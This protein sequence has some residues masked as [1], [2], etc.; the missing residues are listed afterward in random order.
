[1]DKLI[2]ILQT[3]LPV[4]LALGV[5]VFARRKQFLTRDSIDA[6]KKLVINVTLPFVLLSA[7]ASADYNRAALVLPTMVFVLCSVA[8]ALGFVIL[9][10]CKVKS[11][12]APFL[13]SGFEAG[14]LGYSLFVL[15]FPE[16]S[17]STFAVLDLGQTL[18]VFTLFKILLSGK[19]DFRAIARDMVTSPILWAVFAGVILGVTGLYRVPNVGRLLDATCDFLSAPTGMVI[20]LTVG[21]DLVLGEIPWKK[22]V[23][24]IAMRLGV[25]AVIL[26]VMVL[27]NRTVLDGMMFEGAALLMVILPPPYV[28][29]VFA[30]EPSERVSISSALSAMTVVSLL[31]FAALSI[32]IGLR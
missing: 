18:F 1:M 27:L 28:I 12:L 31:L 29:P 4:F 17:V 7:F 24:Y 2:T 5:G 10:L 32:I 23:G 22:T 13:A 25:M 6:M 15:L 11:R 8:L 16:H 21:Y 26:A 14:M 9:R 19:T 30:D 3:A 20:L